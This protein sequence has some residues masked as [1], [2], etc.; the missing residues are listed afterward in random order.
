[1][2][3]NSPLL[4]SC[5]STTY[6]KRKL[7]QLSLDFNLK[8]ETFR[9]LFPDLVQ[10]IQTKLNKMNELKKQHELQNAEKAKAENLDRAGNENNVLANHNYNNIFTNVIIFAL[11]AMFAAVVNY[12]ISLNWPFEWAGKFVRIP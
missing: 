7:A 11:F 12:V 10:E 4:G 6:E 9:E 8:N 1:M 5:E 2:L 3:E